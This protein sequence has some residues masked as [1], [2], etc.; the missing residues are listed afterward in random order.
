MKIKILGIIIYALSFQ[1]FSCHNTQEQIKKDSAEI[2]SILENKDFNKIADYIDKDSGLYVAEK[3][4]APIKYYN[5][6]SFD[7]VVNANGSDNKLPFYIDDD[8]SERWNT[9]IYK[10][11]DATFSVSK[12][13]NK[14][15]SYN[16]HISSI[17]WGLVEH[18]I[19]EIFP[20]SVFVEYY[21][22]PSGL[23]G[24]MDW[25]SIYLIFKEVDNDIVLIGIACNYMGI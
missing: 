4:T 6:L 13:R 5:H 20:D 19:S 12:S 7:D 3:I 11:L 21:Y 14:Q 16:K 17:D 10:F 22:E 15:V 23:Y 8:P 18:S 1:F 25:E 24:D 2:I 9:T